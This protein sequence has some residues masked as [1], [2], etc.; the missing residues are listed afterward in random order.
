MKFLQRLRSNSYGLSLVEVLLSVSL[1][2]FITLSVMGYFIQSVESSAEDSRRIVAIKLAKLKANEIRSLLAGE[3]TAIGELPNLRIRH[4]DLMYNLTDELEPFREIGLT[5][6]LA[7]EIGINKVDYHY[8]FDFV[9]VNQAKYAE[10]FQ[11]FTQGTSPFQ[12]KDYIMKLRV[13]V[14]WG[15]KPDTTVPIKKKSTFV[16]TYVVFWR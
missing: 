8:I 12:A 3:H 16:D 4:Q 2:S 11:S 15:Q 14:F 10:T 7:P 1:M 9:P 13:T 5:N 6:V